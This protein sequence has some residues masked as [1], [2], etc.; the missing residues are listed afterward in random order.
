MF[1]RSADV[2]DLIKFSS[3]S[4]AVFPGLDRAIGFRGSKA[5]DLRGSRVTRRSE[6]AESGP[7]RCLDHF[8]RG[9]N[10]FDEARL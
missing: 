7:G 8:G 10:G 2:V 5:N 1:E 6:T 4:Q 9:W 3:A